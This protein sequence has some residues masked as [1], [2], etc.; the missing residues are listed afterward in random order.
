M[1]RR[2]DSD[3]GWV[4]RRLADLQRQINEQRAAKRLPASTFPPGVIP[5]SALAS[6]AAPG[7]VQLSATNFA[8]AAAG[9]TVLT[10]TITIPSRM[11]NCVVSLTARVY[12]TNT[13]ATSDSLYA[14]VEV[15]TVTGTA[16][17]VTVP[18]TEARVNVATLTTLLTGLTPGAT[19]AVRAWA[20]TLTADWTASGGNTVDISGTLAWFA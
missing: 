15:A 18:T 17:P 7:A 9:A 5:T 3:E 11:T 2:T 19:F 10:G 4:N 14:R 16:L 8:V 6:P 20:K 13:T 12:A 1:V